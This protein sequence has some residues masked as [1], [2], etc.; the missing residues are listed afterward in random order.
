MQGKI[1]RKVQCLNWNNTLALGGI[2]DK[3]TS[4]FISMIQGAHFK[5]RT[6]KKKIKFTTNQP[7]TNQPITTSNKT[8]K[9][10]YQK[11]KTK[12]L[13]KVPV[14]FSSNLQGYAV[15]LGLGRKTMF[16]VTLYE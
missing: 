9:N 3:I 10:K 16:N 13:L 12:C 8:N 2:K 4:L 1:I 11:G 5:L 14:I 15:I 6:L 7:I